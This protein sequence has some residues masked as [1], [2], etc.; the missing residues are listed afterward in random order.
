MV[1]RTLDDLRLRPEQ[2]LVVG[3]T[4]FD[5]AMGQGARC[6]TCGVTYGNQSRSQLEKQK[7]DLIIDSFQQLV[8]LIS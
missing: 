6:R 7:P 4:V 5:I 1:L 3:D 8:E 2:V